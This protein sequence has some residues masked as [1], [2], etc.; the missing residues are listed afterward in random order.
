M[1]LMRSLRY[2]ASDP[3]SSLKC[4]RNMQKRLPWRSSQLC[5][6]GCEKRP[7]A[8]EFSRSAATALAASR[9]DWYIWNTV[10]AKATI[11]EA[12]KVNIT[13]TERTVGSSPEKKA[14]SSIPSESTPTLST[15]LENKTDTREKLQSKLNLLCPWC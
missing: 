3:A 15:R 4:E 1:R 2:R 8:M 5:D 9:V 14:G 13:A 11:T 7:R 12:S 6:G 10:S